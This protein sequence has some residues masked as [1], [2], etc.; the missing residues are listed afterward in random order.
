MEYGLDTESSEGLTTT[1]TNGT[2]LNPRQKMLAV[3][4]DFGTVAT[5]Y[6]QTAA[7]DFLAKYDPIYGS[8][9]SAHTIVAAGHLV[10]STGQR[11]QRALAYISPNISGLT[12]AVNYVTATA[13]LGQLTQNDVGLNS[14]FSKDTVFMMSGNYAVDALSVGAVYA[15]R[16]QGKNAAGTA[17]PV[18]TEFAFGGSYDLGV[19]KVMGT[20]QSSKTDAANAKA[21]TVFS[22]A[23]V[24]PVPTG[25]FAVM[26]ASNANANQSTATVS[27]SSK[28]ATA[29][30][31]GY[32]HTFTKNTTGYLVFSNVKNGSATNGYSVNGNI[33]GSLGVLAAATQANGGSSNLFGIGLRKKF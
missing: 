17:Q 14:S 6:L 33:L 12:V 18:T 10:G 5:G 24:M 23:G 21:D 30:T 2:N 8:G 11:A 15:K 9:S 32:L 28:S 1:G 26:Y 25:A 29:L 20:Y 31:A 13:G 16:D 27:T 22:L 4:G 3:A 7:Y 19:A